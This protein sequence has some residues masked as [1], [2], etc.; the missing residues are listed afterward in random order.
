VYA[1]EKTIADGKKLPCW[2][3][4]SI[5]CVNMGLSKKH[6]NTV[7]LVLN[8]ET[9]YITPQY[10]IVFDDWFAMVATNVDALPDFNTTRWGRLF[11]NSRYQFPFNDDNNSDAT[12]EA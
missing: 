8:P 12:E 7:P 5:C 10:H 11:S 2:K 9:G 1:L 4:W 6:A 3:P